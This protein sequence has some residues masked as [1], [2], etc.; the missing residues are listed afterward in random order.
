MKTP[1]KIQV[2]SFFWDDYLVGKYPEHA[3]MNELA[4]GVS[5][6]SRANHMI[7]SFNQRIEDIRQNPTA[8]IQQKKLQMERVAKRTKNDLEKLINSAGITQQKIMEESREKIEGGIRSADRIA[9]METRQKLDRM[10]DREKEK[11]I[12][13]LANAGDW[14]SLSHIVG[15]T[16]TYLGVSEEAHREAMESYMHGAFPKE[17]KKLK[18]ASE[19][20][21][22][23]KKGYSAVAN[24]FDQFESGLEAKAKAAEK[25]LKGE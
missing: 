10:N 23:Y 22:T 24:E 19:L 4:E 17:S 15:R 3:E 18:I 5:V 25:A 13:Q 21:K 14:D 11:F 12:R 8:T 9:A 6:T 20:L 7:E 2:P 16:H 1:K